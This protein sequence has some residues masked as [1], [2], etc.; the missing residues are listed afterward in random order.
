MNPVAAVISRSIKEGKWVYIEYDNKKEEKLTYFWISIRDIDPKSR[1]LFV[2]L[3][4]SEKRLDVLDGAVYFDQI[5]KA[6]IIEGTSCIVQTDLINKILSNYNE[7]SFLEYSGINERI[8]EYYRQC[9]H[10]DRDGVV[11]RYNLVNGI[12]TEIFQGKPVS[13]S[14]DQFREFILNLKIHQK[15][16]NRKNNQEIIRLAINVFGLMTKKGLIPIVYRD[17]LLNVEKK[18]LVAAPA[19][20]Y[21][22]RLVDDKELTHFDLRNYFDG[23]ASDFMSQFP[24]HSNDCIQEIASNLRYGEIIDERPYVFK[25]AQFIPVSIQ[26]DYARIELHFNNQQLCAPLKAFFGLNEKERRRKPKSLLTSSSSINI[27]Q[28][29]V[30]YHAMIRDIVYVQGP[31]GT[32][33]TAT[34]INVVTSLLLNHS[35]ALIVSNNNEAINNIYRKLTSFTWNKRLIPFPVLRLGSLYSIEESLNTIHQSLEQ[36]YRLAQTV[37]KKRIK[38]L[39]N[40]FLNTLTPL[41]QSIT[42]S[43]EKSELLEQIESL[44]EVIKTINQQGTIDE[45]SKSM[46]IMGIRAQMDRLSSSINKIE[47]QNTL[48]LCQF[49]PELVQEYLWQRSIEQ[50]SLL[51]SKRNLP[52]L[53]IF[54]IPEKNDRLQ[55]FRTFLSQENNE[56][57]RILKECFPFIISTNISCTKLGNADPIF[58][59]LIMDEASQCSNALALLALAR[60]KRA[61]FVGDQNQLQPVVVINPDQN[62]QFLKNYDI[63]SPYNYRENS[64]LSTLLKVDTLSKFILLREHYRCH[65]KIIN[66]SN[67][68]YYGGELQ[69]KSSLQNLDA[70]KLIDVNSSFNNEKNTSYEEVKAI[71]EEI[72]RTNSQNIAVITPFRKQ[73]DYIERELL[74]NRLDYVKVG[75]VHTFQGD[76]KT[77]IILSSGISK[78]TQQ[79]SYNWLKNNQELINVATTRAKENLVLITDVN[80]IRELSKDESNDFL[81]LVEYI[82]NDGAYEVRYNE[83]ELFNSKVKNFKYYNTK[84]EEEFLKTLLHLRSVEGRIRIASKVKITDVLSL[85]RSD[86]A[87]FTYGNQAHFDFVIYNMQNMPLL[88]IEVMG[89]EHY[90]SEKVKERDKKKSLICKQ[91][92]LSLITIRNDYVRRYSYIKDT[93]MKAL[94]D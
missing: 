75:T 21:N 76:E 63:P 69:L 2:L 71:I 24:L 12:D 87:L 55:S 51:F 44:Q 11:Q 45:I 59:L 84:S 19:F 1:K 33:K 90:N 47:E 32:G 66:F 56:G 65:S 50:I 61:L 89:A 43:E 38:E 72:R 31:P 77:K 18:E 82:R 37:N 58:D 81:E 35:N 70:L 94:K 62:S 83:N 8:L 16:K 29:R 23:S 15:N 3:F 93:I 73:A 42:I 52:L 67:Q 79:G 13:L 7:Y 78:S 40:L 41:T 46:A 34:I 54:R 92:N 9:Y 39:E 26:R 85:S 25:M 53:N 60:A 10:H 80:K 17:L 91:H 86:R 74:K 6:E 5:L 20:S 14:D 22:L 27:D 68:K 30:L 4:N 49:D 36:W 28:L 48:D 64:I 88:A 57:I